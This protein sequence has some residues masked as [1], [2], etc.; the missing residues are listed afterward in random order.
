MPHVTL[1][2]E[3]SNPVKKKKVLLD[4]V[5]SVQLSTPKY[6]WLNPEHW[7]NSLPAVPFWLI[8]S[9]SKQSLFSI[10]PLSSSLTM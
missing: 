8:T 2:P 6:K 7:D 4:R 1:F 10:I 9:L 5:A 3:P